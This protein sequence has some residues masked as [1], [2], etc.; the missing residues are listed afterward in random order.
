MCDGPPLKIWG[1]PS[2]GV[3][4]EGSRK[5]PKE[6]AYLW[7]AHPNEVLNAFPAINPNISTCAGG[8]YTSEGFSLSN[9]VRQGGVISPTCSMCTL[10]K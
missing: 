5:T 2:N 10:M 3:K 7:V 6:K 8:N 1:G 9:G 4:R